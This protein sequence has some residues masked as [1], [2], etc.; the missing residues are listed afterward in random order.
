MAGGKSS[1]TV[2]AGETK[3]IKFK[4]NG[5]YTWPDVS[6]HNVF[7]DFKFDGKKYR[8]WVNSGDCG[9]YKNGKRWLYTMN[10]Y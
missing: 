10:D 6:S 4:V 3:T 2:K 1:V 5:Y 7:F 8:A 9:G